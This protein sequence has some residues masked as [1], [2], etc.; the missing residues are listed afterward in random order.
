M[1]A[2]S[3]YGHRTRV[4]LSVV[5]EYVQLCDALNARHSL[6]LTG[7]APWAISTASL[8]YCLYLN[9]TTCPYPPPTE[10]LS[11]A[12]SSAAHPESEGHEL[13]RSDFAHLPPS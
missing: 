11:G 7:I 5:A 1:A 6:T 13:L 10:E 4:R 3:V 9:V 8:S 12:R 2:M